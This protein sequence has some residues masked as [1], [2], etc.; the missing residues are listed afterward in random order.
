LFISIVYAIHA[1][2][3]RYGIEIDSSELSLV[4]LRCILWI[5]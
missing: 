2:A 3:V 4:L 5:W 1:D